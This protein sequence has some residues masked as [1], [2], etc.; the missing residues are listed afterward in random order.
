MLRF[1]QNMAI[2][3]TNC[4]FPHYSHEKQLH[5]LDDYIFYAFP[6]QCIYTIKHIKPKEG[7]HSKEAK[8][9]EAIPS[10]KAIFCGY[11][12]NSS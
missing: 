1:F 12:M 5:A 8:S 9:K 4:A 11:F 10:P 2:L 7:N 6:P 3:H